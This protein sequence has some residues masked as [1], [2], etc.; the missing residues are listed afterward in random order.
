VRWRIFYEVMVPS[1]AKAM[2]GES[3]EVIPGFTCG[4]GG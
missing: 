3:D 2:A 1:F 4:Y